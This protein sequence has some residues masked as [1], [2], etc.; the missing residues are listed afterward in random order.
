MDFADS[1]PS[2]VQPDRYKEVV[3][4]LICGDLQLWASLI[5]GNLFFSALYEKIG[6][7][8]SVAGK[9]RCQFE[10]IA[11]KMTELSL[12][13]KVSVDN[14]ENCWKGIIQVWT[15][16]KRNFDSCH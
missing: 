10:S 15:D 12:L 14:V 9:P 13:R 7:S 6:S 11:V 16:V 8:C 1:H 4:V 2:R 3:V 5:G